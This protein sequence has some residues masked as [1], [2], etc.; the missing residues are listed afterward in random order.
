MKIHCRDV[1]CTVPTECSIRC[2][3]GII[4]EALY[5]IPTIC[6]HLDNSHVDQLSDMGIHLS[7]YH[8]LAK[9]H[10]HTESTQG[11]GQDILISST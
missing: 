5:S 8:I 10:G 2:M 11:I 1:Q 7:N 3:Y 9:R 6:S 4:N